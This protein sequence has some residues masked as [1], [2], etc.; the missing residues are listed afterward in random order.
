MPDNSCITDSLTKCDA[1][2]LTIRGCPDPDRH[3]SES[4]DD[5]PL[6]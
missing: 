5:L 2:E 3:R 6:G 4:D 1:K